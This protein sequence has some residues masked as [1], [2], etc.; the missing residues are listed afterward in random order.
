MVSGKTGRNIHHTLLFY[1]GA[2]TL[3]AIYRS[4]RNHAAETA[5]FVKDNQLFSAFRCV[6]VSLRNLIARRTKE[7]K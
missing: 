4:D 6:L 3:C 5:L 2:Q 1:K 7:A